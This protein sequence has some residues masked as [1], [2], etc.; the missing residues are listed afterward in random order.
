MVITVTAVS[1]YHYVHTLLDVQWTL[2]AAVSSGEFDIWVGGL[3]NGWFVGH[4]VTHV[5]GQTVYTH[6]IDIS[7]VIPGDHYK[8]IVGYR[9]TEGSGSWTTYQQAGYFF[10][11]H[12]LRV[13]PIVAIDDGPAELPDT[14]TECI[15]YSYD[16]TSTEVRETAH[17]DVNPNSMYSIGPYANVLNANDAQCQL[18][19]VLYS[20]NHSHVYG[21]VTS[22]LIRHYNG[23][24][25]KTGTLPGSNADPTGTWDDITDHDDLTLSGFA[26]ANAVAATNYCINPKL[27]PVSTTGSTLPGGFSWYS[28]TNTNIELSKGG[29]YGGYN[30]QHI[31][32]TGLTGCITT[33]GL[34]IRSGSYRIPG[35][36]TAG[37]KIYVSAVVGEATMTNCSMML[38]VCFYDVNY[39][40]VGAYSA[41]QFTPGS[42][43]V[44]YELLTA[45]APTGASMFVAHLISNWTFHVNDI[46]E[47]SVAEIMV[48][49]TTATSL[50]WFSG[51]SPGCTWESTVNGSKSSRAATVVSGWS[52]YGLPL[53]PYNLCFDGVDDVATGTVTLDSNSFT[54]EMWLKD[55]DEK[56]GWT[57]RSPLSLSVLAG[58]MFYPYSTHICAGTWNS[59]ATLYRYVTS[60]GS[61]A[62]IIGDDAWHH[63]VMTVGEQYLKLYVDGTD[64]G[65]TDITT[66]GFV[67]P[68]LSSLR[69]GDRGGGGKWSGYIADIKIYQRPLTY[70][71]VLQNYAA[72]PLAPIP[73]VTRVVPITTL[74]ADTAVWERK[75]VHVATTSLE[76]EIS[77]RSTFSV[78]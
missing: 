21:I 7:T 48:S 13:F 4:V 78:P 69:V 23:Q 20:N 10:V 64:C 36:V 45:A 9:A 65:E 17:V 73:S 77:F 8:V 62:S 27:Y 15:V 67:M 14:C 5:D 6:S 50:D 29:A 39:A 55:P 40:L 46:Q 71:E 31:K 74:V 26:Y 44:K 11:Y 51:S 56:D 25:A 43:F 57:T 2:D 47:Y 75:T 70:A 61:H 54:L 19:A 28:S 76:D 58:F 68:S 42:S 1:D 52:G 38:Y 32:I 37:D 30:S 33:A 22:D 3:V 66:G 49:K 18:D 35:E 59:G 63:C 34:S 53:H 24:R 72:G 12:D 41:T 60:Y 16:G